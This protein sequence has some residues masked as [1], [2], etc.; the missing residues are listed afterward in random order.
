[1]KKI[2]ISQ[3]MA[4]KTSEEILKAR[5]KA[6]YMASKKL[7]DNVA[8]IDSYF[9]EYNSMDGYISLKYLSKSLELMAEAD[10]VYFVKGWENSRGCKIEHQC[11]VSYG[12]DMI[13]EDEEIEN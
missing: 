13:T 7:N 9:K 5:T 3:P 12:I 1:M 8:V 4:G 2:F 11:A 6:A 10:V